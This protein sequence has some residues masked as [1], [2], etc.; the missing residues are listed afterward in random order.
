MRIFSTMKPE[1]SFNKTINKLALQ[2]DNTWSL[3]LKKIWDPQ[4]HSLVTLDRNRFTVQGYQKYWEAVDKTLKYVDTI[5][6][7]KPMKKPPVKVENTSIPAHEGGHTEEAKKITDFHR[8]MMNVHDRWSQRN[9]RFHW[10]KDHDYHDCEVKRRHHRHHE[11]RDREE[12]LRRHH[13]HSH[14][15]PQRRY[16]YH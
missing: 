8:K 11:H 3:Q 4:D 15:S 7:K 10:H 13:G 6:L 16:S 14:S 5:L 12:T 1:T 2:Y 9:D